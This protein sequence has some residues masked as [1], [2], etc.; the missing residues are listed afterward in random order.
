MSLAVVVGAGGTGVAT[1][2]LLA[3]AGHR[4]RLVT[5]GGGGPEHPSIERVAADAAD[6]DRL[7]EVARGAA[8]LFNCAAPPYH[9]WPTALP[10]LAEGLLTAAERTGADYV[11]L[12]NLYAY[13]PVEGPMTEDLPLAPA[14]VKGRVRA[15][16]WRQA[17]A[18]HE[19]G[20]VRL[21]TVRASDFIGA[22]AYSVITVTVAP[23]VLA[24]KPALV[25]ADLDAP[26]SWTA[27]RDAARALVTVAQDERAWGRVWHAPT[28]PPVSV[29][30]LAAGLARLAEV[31]EPRL[32]AMPGWL[33]RAGG[34]FSPVAREL[35]EMQ[36]QF[37]Q[38]F[39]LDSSRI[40]ETFDLHPTPLDD[41]LQ[42]MITAG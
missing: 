6:A 11:M 26:H 37:Q 42:E 14:S 41:V 2:R 32:R 5:R 31:R 9:T 34:L 38:P 20:R 30:E 35:P 29:R 40:E 19:A 7:S 39:V 22:G 3:D 24:G 16:V 25:P 15:E 4:V 12:D 36:Y 28:P 21:T 27:T 10:P 18:A 8:T 33:L 13:G 1:A 17:D 23:K